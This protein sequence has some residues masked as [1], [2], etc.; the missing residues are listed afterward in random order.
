[1]F[2]EIGLGSEFFEGLVAIDAEITARVAAAGCRFCGG[3]LHRG[4]YDRKPRGGA[5][6]VAA[7]AFTRR[8]SLCCG[9][10][11]CRRRAMPPSVRFL[12]R[13]VAWGE[14]RSSSSD[15]SART[16]A[17][18]AVARAQRIS[19]TIERTSRSTTTDAQRL[20][21]VSLEQN[22]RSNIHAGMTTV[23]WALGSEQTKTSSP[24]RFSR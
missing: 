19:S 9:R 12:G 21:S 4:D 1:M 23:A 20:P 14:M 11:G 8:F 18:D 22:A 5:V 24:P 17:E 13:R 16:V 3:P 6:A 2:G 10:E 7:E 15:S